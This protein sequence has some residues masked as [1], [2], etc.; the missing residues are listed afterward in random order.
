[1]ISQYEIAEASAC[2]AG[3][4]Q[5]DRQRFV[6]DLRALGYK[7]WTLRRYE[8]VAMRFCVTVEAHGLDVDGLNGSQT[9]QLRAAVLETRRRP[10][11]PTHVSASIALSIIS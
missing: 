8:D 5:P 4:L 9:E 10:P 7:P 6:E 1:M 2:A 11:A 3:W